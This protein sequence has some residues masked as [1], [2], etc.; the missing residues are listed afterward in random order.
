MTYDYRDVLIDPN[1]SRLELGVK[2]YYGLNPTTVVRSANSD[3]SDLCDILV[4]IRDKEVMP[5]YMGHGVDA[6]CL[7]RKQDSELVPFDLSNEED[8]GYL[9]HSMVK[10]ERTDKLCYCEG[11][12]T[13][14]R[15]GDEKWKALVCNMEIDADQLFKDWTFLDGTKV[16]KEKV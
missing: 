9:F 11:I 3:N 6:V 8:R 12:I 14:F 7:I 13:G 16:G 1:D 15:Q 5:F 10:R 2:Y 4:A